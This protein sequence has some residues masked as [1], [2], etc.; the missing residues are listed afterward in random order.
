MTI[1]EAIDRNRSVVDRLIDQAWPFDA[2]AVLL[3]I[4][5]LK[6]IKSRRGVDEW[7]T[8]DLLPGETDS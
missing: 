5:A 6:R 7:K 2:K 4:E 3:G 8:M 1:E